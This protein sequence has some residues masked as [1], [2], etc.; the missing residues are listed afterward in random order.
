[1]YNTW[2]DFT[3]FRR[4]YNRAHGLD[5]RLPEV[6]MVSPNKADYK[7][8]MGDSER[9]DRIKCSLIDFAHSRTDIGNRNTQT[10]RFEHFHLVAKA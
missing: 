2:V 3:W 10:V 4:K 5:V 9:A 7:S 8:R 6:Q 1:M